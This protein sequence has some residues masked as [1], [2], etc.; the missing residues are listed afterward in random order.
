[1]NVGQYLLDD[2]ADGKTSA[3]LYAFLSAFSLDADKRK[4]LKQSLVGSDVL[5]CWAPG[6]LSDSGASLKTIQDL[7]GFEVSSV[8]VSAVVN[9]DLSKFPIGFPE[10][11]GPSNAIY[12][13]FSP[14][15]ENGD[16]VLATY[17]SGE[18]AT[19]LRV[20]K[21][22]H[23]SVFCGT[24]EI[25][26][27]LYRYLVKRSGVFLYTESD[28]HLW[29]PGPYLGIHA[30]NKGPIVLKFPKQVSVVDEISKKDFGSVSELSLD[31]A[32]GETRLFFLK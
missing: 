3:K 23:Y 18:P 9:A 22:G 28:L 1:V 21:N 26:T 17:A 24:P 31:L 32:L 29:K 25:P 16:E 13:L 19:V 30:A 8:S 12:P 4:K 7:T 6:L 20:L 10:H 11:F 2:V 27:A 5:W 15:L 14:K